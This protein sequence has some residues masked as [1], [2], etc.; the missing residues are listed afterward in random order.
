MRQ[1]AK[2]AKV[3]AG[4][5]AETERLALREFTP[6]DAP[7]VLRLLNEPSFLHNIG[8]RGVR[9]ADEAS[10]YLSDGPIASYARYGHGLYLVALKPALQ[11][12]GMCGLLKR[13]GVRDVDLGY[14]FLPEFWSNGYA[15]ESAEAVLGIA[16]RLRL[17]RVAAFVSP[18]NAPSIRLL[19]KLGFSPAGETK[20]EPA[21]AP[22]SIYRLQL[23]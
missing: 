7:F 3:H 22:V 21:A 6:A 23:R 15:L 20:L 11:P 4:L 10:R 17:T 14:A 19:D 12:I 16:R 2:A 13:D 8:D 9:T 18:G 1:N 5:V